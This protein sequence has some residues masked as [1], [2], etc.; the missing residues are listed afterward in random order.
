MT[1][2]NWKPTLSIWWM[3]VAMRRQALRAR[4]SIF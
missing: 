4:R 1:Y 3:N 2:D